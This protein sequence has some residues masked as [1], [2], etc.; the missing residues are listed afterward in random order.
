MNTTKFHAQDFYCLPTEYTY[1]FGM[2]FLKTVEI[3]L[4]AHCVISYYNRDEVHLLRGASW[5]FNII[6]VNL[7]H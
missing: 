3:F 5:F 4:H 6:K 2:V 1:V 7:G